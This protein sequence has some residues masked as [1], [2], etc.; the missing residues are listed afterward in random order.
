MQVHL[1]NLWNMFMHLS[2]FTSLCYISHHHSLFSF[3]FWANLWF[4][5]H[6]LKS[7]TRSLTNEIQS[8]WGLVPYQ[9]RCLPPPEARLI[10][11]HFSP[12]VS[13]HETYSCVLNKQI[14][15]HVSREIWNFFLVYIYNFFVWLSGCPHILFFL[16]LVPHSSSL[17]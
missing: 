4:W 9:S 1:S 15:I 3:H 10:F 12:E 13:E 16:D 6:I 14:G 17:Y 5:N 2:M 8:Y 11:C 7:I